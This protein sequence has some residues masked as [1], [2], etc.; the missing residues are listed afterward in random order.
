MKNLFFL[1]FIL[2]SGL[3][4]FAQQREVISTAG[5]DVSVDGVAMS[6]TIGEAVVEMGNT[7]S[8]FLTAGFQQS[9][10]IISNALPNEE[11]RLKAKVFPN[12]AKDYF[13]L[14]IEQNGKNEFFMVLHNTK[15][16]FIL[17]QNINAS[18]LKVSLSGF[19]DGI[20]YLTL[21]NQE[22]KRVQQ[23]KVLKTE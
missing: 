21:L 10:I 3:S 16:Q 12:P 13:Y 1:S 20:Y 22:N 15:G 17:R 4:M 11:V 19:P 5:D 9:N 2:L 8:I 7:D 18:P 14:E 23:F 6:F